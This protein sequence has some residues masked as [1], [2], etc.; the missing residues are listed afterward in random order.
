M[1]VHKGYNKPAGVHS[2]GSEGEKKEGKLGQTR[3]PE[4]TLGLCEVGRSGG[5]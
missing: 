3:K 4:K 5:A 1:E 2:G